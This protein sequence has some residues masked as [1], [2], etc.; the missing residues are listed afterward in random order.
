MPDGQ[1]IVP[2]LSGDE[3]LDVSVSRA[4]LERLCSDLFDQ[5]SA[6]ASRL[7]QCA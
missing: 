2:S 5:C 3:D 1:V 4:D 7:L 6:L